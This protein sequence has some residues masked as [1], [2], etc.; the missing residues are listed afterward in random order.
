M[1]VPLAIPSA[2]DSTGDAIRGVR[3]GV[4][5]VIVGWKQLLTLSLP[6]QDYQAV[7]APFLILIFVAV[8][9]ATILASRGGAS[10]VVVVPIVFAMNAFGPLF[11][12]SATGAPVVVAGVALPAPEHLALGVAL[13][14]VS[15]VWLVGRARLN[16]ARSLRAARAQ[17]GTVRQG[18]QSIAF[19]IRRNALAGVLLLIAIVAG[20]AFA[21]ASAGIQP[22]HALRDGIDPDLVVQQQASPLSGYRAWFEASHFSSPIFTIAGDTR[23][24]DRIQLATLDLYDGEDFTVSGADAGQSGRFTRLPR[25]APTS[26]QDSSLT[27]TIGS[28]YSGIWVPVP[29]GLAAAPTFS[30][31]RAAE[32]SD[33]FYVS[34][35]DSSAIDV[36]ANGSGRAGLRP[37]DSYRV[38]AAPS[39][40]TSTSLGAGSPAQSEINA[41]DY[42][43]LVDW[44]K[45]QDVPRTEEGLQE[46][47]NRLV[48]RGYLSHSVAQTTS[49]K[50]WIAALKSRSPYT[51]EPSYSGHSVARI[52]T[53]FST[54]L[55]QQRTAGNRATR[56]QLVSG[57]GDD[58]QF[59]VA[60]ALLARYFGYDSRV[61]LGV[62]LTA[63]ASSGVAPCTAT[64]TG[65]NVSAWIQV[66]RSGGPWVTFDTTPQFTVAPTSISAGEQLPSNP[67]VP[68]Q[69]KNTVV[70]AP[71]VNRDSSDARSARSPGNSGWLAVLLPVLRVAGISLL[72]LLFLLLPAIVI[73]VAKRYRRRGRR[74]AKVPEVSLVGAWYEL[75][76]IYVDNGIP[77]PRE[78][79][80]SQLARVSGRPSAVALA[81]AVDRAVFAEHPPGRESSEAAWQIVDA[82]RLAF[83]LNSSFRRRLATQ[84]GLS[85]FLRQ[86]DPTSIPAAVFARFSRTEYTQ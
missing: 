30:G 61:V 39:S 33:A 62:R 36:V 70:Q 69:T 23:N 32:L 85:S 21:P 68:A 11:A 77:M 51:F 31:S 45:Q 79:T 12:S 15:L 10:A 8:L 18:N 53:L 42:P 34:G 74:E 14:L 43:A 26:A 72:V 80:R 3:D 56:A 83:R 13:V 40:K 78:A 2:L 86:L 27:I 76:D 19:A 38:Y 73:L 5:A 37:G 67:T 64:C 75:V 71:L 17:T 41:A 59:A 63:P 52:E 48:A 22:R 4:A 66:A 81:A 35:V 57:V 29:E 55:S 50:K 24:V 60:G 49:A 54:M 25:T 1:V 9:V 47:L 65:S 84:L 16:R 7:L 46:L 6:L 28:A 20:L 44:V 58:E 82:E